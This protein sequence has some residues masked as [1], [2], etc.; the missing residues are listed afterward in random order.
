MRQGCISAILL[1]AAL[2]A[3][4]AAHAAFPYQYGG[5]APSDLEGKTEWM[6]AATPEQGNALVNADPQEL[7]GVRGASH[8]RHLDQSVKTAW[9]IT[10]GRPDVTIAVLD[11]G[12]KWNDAGAMSDLRRKV[13]LN[14][15]SCRRRTRRRRA[16]PGANCGGYTTR[17]DCQRRRRLQRARLR[18]RLARGPP[19]PAPRRARRTSLDAAGPADRVLGRHATTTATASST[20][21]PAG[22]SST[23]TTTRST[24]SST[25]T[26]PARRATRRRGRT[27]AATSARC[28]NCTVLPL[29][30]G[31]S[32]IADVNRFAQAVALRGRQ[33]RERRAGGARHAE[34][35]DARAR[36]DRL[37]LRPRRDGHRVGRRRGRPAPQ[38]A[39]DAA[40]RDRR[41]LG[42]RSTTTRSRR[43]RAPTCSSTAARTSR[44]KIT[45]RDPELDL[46][47][48]APPAAAGIAGLI[49][50]AALNAHDAPALRPHCAVDG[51]AAS[52]AE[53]GAPAVL[54]CPAGTADDVNFADATGAHS[55]APVPAPPRCTDPNLNSG[56]R[57]PA[58][59]C[60]PVADDAPLP[61]AQGLR[62]VLRL[63]APE[64]ARRRARPSPTAKIPPAAAIDLAGLVRAGRSRPGD[65]RRA[66]AQV[67][68]ARRGPYT[69]ALLVAPGS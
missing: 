5:T 3:A 6:Y 13:R 10:T 17:Y 58:R 54:P 28:P 15:A 30:V 37:R 63:R 31:E 47:V 8:R 21:S 36:R 68:R 66:A 38:L 11:S 19:R 53:R 46:L 62:P 27:T 40:A 29:R 22:T 1:A 59:S 24:T 69:C 12:I 20:T 48:G 64:H 43:S 42:R 23:T 61:G 2:F 52:H 50:S 49:Y 45:R 39:G 56:L 9:K 65:A 55:C 16:R 18:V 67:V 26:A 51:S 60:S 34:Q 44:R 14:R 33:R 41:Q 25:A 4:P 7:G 57:Q 35:L 32:F